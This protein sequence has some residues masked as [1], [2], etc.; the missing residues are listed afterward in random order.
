GVSEYSRPLLFRQLG[1]D[2]TDALGDFGGGAL[3]H[4][5]ELAEPLVAHSHQRTRYGNGADRFTVFVIDGGTDAAHAFGALFVVDRPATL[6][7]ACEIREQGGG[8]DDGALGDAS[9]A[10]AVQL[11]RH[12]LVGKR[13]QQ[14]LAEARGVQLPARAGAVEGA[15]RVVT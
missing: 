12:G 13:R 10:G 9:H 4:R 7:R 11:L 2:A 1:N 3:D 15:D 8:I 14:R 6:A 5:T